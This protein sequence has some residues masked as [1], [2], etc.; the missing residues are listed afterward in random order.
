MKLT[1]IKI[2]EILPEKGCPK[3]LGSYPST[4][5]KQIEITE[6]RLR[7]VKKSVT[8]FYCE[9]VTLEGSHDVKILIPRECV[10]YNGEYWRSRYFLGKV[11]VILSN[12]TILLTRT[13][14]LYDIEEVIE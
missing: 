7:G 8:N 1:E 3:G 11:E 6:V 4:V 10:E 12:P 5:K 9:F 2:D 14:I 13:D